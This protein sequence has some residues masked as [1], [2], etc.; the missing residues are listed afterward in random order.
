MAAFAISGQLAFGGVSDQWHTPPPPPGCT[1][2]V[3]AW[4]IGAAVLA[5]ALAEVVRRTLA[6]PANGY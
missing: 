1:P 6:K 5:L 3:N 2:E 4:M